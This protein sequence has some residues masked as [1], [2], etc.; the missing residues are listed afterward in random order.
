MFVFFSKN[1]SILQLFILLNIFL[2]LFFSLDL[3]FSLLADVG[4]FP[5]GLYS[6]ESTC[7]AGNPGLIPGSVEWKLP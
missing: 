1:Q 3:N 6:K 2:V 5:G 4:G 7:S